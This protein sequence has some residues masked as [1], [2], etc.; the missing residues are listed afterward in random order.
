MPSTS[1][2]SSSVAMRTRL[3]RAVVSCQRNTAPVGKEPPTGRMPSPKKAAVS[4]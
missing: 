3:I 1:T 4:L 2:E